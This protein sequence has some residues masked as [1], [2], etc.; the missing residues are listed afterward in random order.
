MKRRCGSHFG[1]ADQRVSSRL[2][3]FRVRQRSSCFLTKSDGSFW[4]EDVFRWTGRERLVPTGD[5]V[6]EKKTHLESGSNRR[7]YVI[8]EYV[9][10][11]CTYK[12]TAVEAQTTSWKRFCS[13][14]AK[15]KVLFVLCCAESSESAESSGRQRRT[16]KTVTGEAIAVGPPFTRA[17]MKMALEAFNPKKAPR[18]DEFTA[19]ICRTAVGPD[20]GLF[21]AIAN[22]SFRAGTLSRF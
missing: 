8:E 5:H 7:A 12:R 9:R 14:Q 11:R 21:L 1:K 15:E 18:I 16:E 10:V 3:S 20:P 13:A 4:N 19:N 17:E 22:K 2:W 6:Q